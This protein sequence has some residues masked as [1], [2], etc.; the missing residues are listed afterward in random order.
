M[1]IIPGE[2]V[3]AAAIP[4]WVEAGRSPRALWEGEQAP[5]FIESLRIK[6]GIR[7]SKDGHMGD[8]LDL[9]R[10]DNAEGTGYLP[11]LLEMEAS[12]FA[13]TEDFLAGQPG[14]EELAVYQETV[15]NRILG[16]LQAVVIP[17]AEPRPTSTTPARAWV[18]TKP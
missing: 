6:W 7:P 14:P 10:L 3:T 17:G 2:P 1:W 12:I 11:G 8:Y 16:H 13:E 4:L 5:L 15:A 9:S 18:Y